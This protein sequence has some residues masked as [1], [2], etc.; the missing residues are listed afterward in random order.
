MLGEN[1]FM[2]FFLHKSNINDN[3]EYQVQYH[4]GKI[5]KSKR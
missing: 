3:F 2:I 5:N 4:R 1:F